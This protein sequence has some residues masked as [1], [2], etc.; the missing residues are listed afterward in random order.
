[1]SRNFPSPHCHVMSLDSAS[2]PE[3]FAKREVELGTGT[4]TCTD[5]GSL[6]AVYK[7]FELA[8]KNNLT[9]IPGI[10]MYFRDDSCPILTKAGIIKTNTV[11]RGCDKD[12]WLEDHPDGSF[13]DYNKYFH[14]TLG[15]RDY[16]AYLKG[17]KLLSKADDRAELHGSERKPLFTWEDIEELAA[18]NTTMG[19]ACLVGM[20]S[21]HLLNTDVAPA[22]KLQIAKSYFER[23]RHLFKDRFFVELFPHVCT[24]E[25]EKGIFIEAQKSSGQIESLRYYYGKTLRTSA[26]KEIKAEELANKW[27]KKQELQL[28][29]VK[30]YR[31]WE[32]FPEPLKI[33][34][35]RKQD[36]FIQNECSPVAPN[37][38]VQWGVNQFMM[39]MAK[40]YG[41]PCQVS[42]DSH[43]ATPQQKIV[44]D[45]K[46][47]QMGDWKFFGSYHRQSSEEAYNY[48]KTQHNI[49][50]K[51][52]ES[53]VDNGYQWAEGFKSFK[54][55]NTI[56]LPTRFFPADTLKHTKELIEKVGRMPKG[57][58]RYVARLKQELE[59]FQKNGTVDLLPYFFVCE[60]IGRLHSNQGILT[61][62]GRGS[63]AGC[64]LSY[65]I[66]I[67][68][69]DPIENDLSLDRFLTIDRINSGR[70]P[71]IDVDFPSR[72]LLVGMECDTIEVEAEDGTKHTLPEW[73]KIETDQG[74]MTVK[75]AV[76]KQA[77]FEKWW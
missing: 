20:V 68:S 28:L 30:N 24:H 31:T 61:G 42:D 14:G 11:P 47:A 54:F 66:G 58:P 21:R 23:L 37:G 73:F 33:L 10:E 5:H 38:D 3:A 50:E 48:F 18:T 6:A 36:G 17:V 52:F 55:D 26:D 7:V 1:M 62:P 49:S 12:K 25:Y 4:L 19:S 2:T 67:T 74:L 45:V 8:K 43:F 40:K 29:A 27:E 70:Y 72:D 77:N 76:D 75:E 32:D 69:V 64:L 46:L 34:H 44:Q 57:D 35:I 59:L 41:V 65:L 22:T 16:D 9:P 56:K 39:R 13:F 53:W 63:A 15:F 60:E 71:D 51:E